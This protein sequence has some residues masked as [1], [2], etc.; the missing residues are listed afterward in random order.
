MYEGLTET[1]P[2]VLSHVA[3]AITNF[4]ESC[5]PI[6]VK[7]YMEKFLTASYTLLRQQG[8]CSLV[9]ECLVTAVSAFA[10]AATDD[11]Q[12]Y[13]QDCIKL[14]IELFSTHNSQPYIKLRGC[15]IE[16]ITII[17]D[18][19]ERDAFKPYFADT[20][21]IMILS[22]NQGNDTVK[23]SNKFL[24]TSFQRLSQS[25]SKDI[26][27]YLDVI[28]PQL[29]AIIQKIFSEQE[30]VVQGQDQKVNTFNHGEAEN[31]IEMIHSFIER[32]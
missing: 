16:T 6:E 19:I 28:M 10:E 3:A 29:Y 27:P 31:A 22:M 14:M 8:S 7:E 21:N 23:I 30:D 18:F 9:K 11:F 5:G 12:P 32:I 1:V 2:R 17:A 26:V 20:I 25:Y 13:F 24:L 4:A 15:I